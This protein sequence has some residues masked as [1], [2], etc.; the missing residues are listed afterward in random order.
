MPNAEFLSGASVH[1]LDGAAG[2]ETA[3]PLVLVADDHEDIRFL[4][5]Y[6]LEARG[7]RVIEAANGLEAVEA[8]L[9]WLPDL[10]LMDVNLPRLDGLSATLRIREGA[11]SGSVAVVAVSGHAAPEDRARALAAGCDGYITKPIDFGELNQVLNSLLPA[12]GSAG[13]ARC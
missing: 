1:A 2:R 9:G 8:A 10:I 5:R 6:M 4:I 13:R 12:R 3:G 11:R 7:C